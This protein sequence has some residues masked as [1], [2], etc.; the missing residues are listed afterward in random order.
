VL[1]CVLSLQQQR[2]QQQQ[3]GEDDAHEDYALATLCRRLAHSIPLWRLHSILLWRLHSILLWRLRA[4]C[5]SHK[6]SGQSIAV[7]VHGVYSAAPLLP[8]TPAAAVLL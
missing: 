1:C 7:A 8:L 6:Y 3:Q 5:G 2:Q 4:L